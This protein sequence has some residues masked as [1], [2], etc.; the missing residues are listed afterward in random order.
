MTPLLRQLTNSHFRSRIHV[1]SK[2]GHP[3]LTMLPCHCPFSSDGRSVDGLTDHC[4]IF[5]M[6]GES[7]RFKESLKEKRLSGS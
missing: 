3:H 5:E 2:T 1:P 6:N 7:I 4:E